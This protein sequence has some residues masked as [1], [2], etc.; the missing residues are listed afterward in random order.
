MR[1]WADSVSLP[2]DEKHR[3]GFQAG[4]YSNRYR[5]NVELRDLTNVVT[6]VFEACLSVTARFDTPPKW[7]SWV[8]TRFQ[9]NVNRSKYRAYRD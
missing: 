9:G 5:V 3:I 8:S 2:F 1:S 7:G 4:G 6:S